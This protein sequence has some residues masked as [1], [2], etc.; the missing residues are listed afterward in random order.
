AERHQGKS[1][2]REARNPPET[3]RSATTAARPAYIQDQPPPSVGVSFEDPSIRSPRRA[4]DP[5]ATG[6]RQAPDER[7]NLYYVSQVFS[8]APAMRA[9]MVD[10]AVSAA[11]N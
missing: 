10:H 3:R 1:P 2:V 8:L 11:A 5:R 6:T 9:S 4:S 7:T